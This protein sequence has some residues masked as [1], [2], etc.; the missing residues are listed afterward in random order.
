[1]RS[2]P[3]SARFQLAGV[4]TVNPA[5]TVVTFTVTGAFPANAT[6]QWY[7]NYNSSIRDM[8][9]LAAAQPVGAVH[10]RQYARRDRTGGA[11]RDAIERLPP[12]SGP[13][14]TVT[15]T[16]SESVNPN[17]VNSTSVALFAG[18]TRLSP[19]LTRSLDNRM[20][21]LT[22][23]L[24]PDATIT[25]VATSDIT[26]LSG[27]AL[28]PFISTFTTHRGIRPDAGRRSSLSARPGSGVAP[29]TPITLFLNKPV[30]PSTCAGRALRVTERR[31]RHR[32][33]VGRQ[34]QPGDR[35]PAVGALRRIGVDRDR[36]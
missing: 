34:R 31:P 33:G 25:V 9:G 11:D 18:P 14:T 17:T 24:P 35:L 30:N 28:A 7:T 22:T 16:F 1:M 36:R 6:I 20:V 21:L 12:D 19:S 15:L 8:A 27:N 23:T 3:G 13:N 10:D 2:L 4:Y 29:T 26:D 32:R 5:G